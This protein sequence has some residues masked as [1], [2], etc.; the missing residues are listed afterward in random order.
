MAVACS[1]LVLPASHIAFTEEA[2]DLK[3][4]LC[5]PEGVR[6]T[7]RDVYRVRRVKVRAGSTL[8]FFGSVLHAG[9]SFEKPAS[10]AAL[11]ANYR[12][13][14]GYTVQGSCFKNDE[15]DVVTPLADF[16]ICKKL[17]GH[18]VDHSGQPRSYSLRPRVQSP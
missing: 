4:P 17:F 1:V 14:A 3:K 16:P 2:C 11:P 18:L 15:L 10:K 12:L 13:H 5:L 9:D 8:L 6:P 7:R